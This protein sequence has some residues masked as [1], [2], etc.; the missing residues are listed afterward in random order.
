MF[1]EIDG[2]MLKDI[3]CKNWPNSGG[4]SKLSLGE[5][6]VPQHS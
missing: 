5:Q 2:D 4:G 3:Y 1:R 6:N